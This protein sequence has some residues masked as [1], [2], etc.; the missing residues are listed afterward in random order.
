MKL[1]AVESADVE[2]NYTFGRAKGF[3][4]DTPNMHMWR[5]KI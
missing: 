5:H 2:K 4:Q 1:D 3:T